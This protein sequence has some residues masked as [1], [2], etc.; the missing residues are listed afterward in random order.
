MF[1]QSQGMFDRSSGTPGQPQTMYEQ[2]P[3]QGGRLPPVVV[4]G[5]ITIVHRMPSQISRTDNAAP[6]TAR[7]PYYCHG[8]SDSKT[9]HLSH[10]ILAHLTVACR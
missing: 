5:G 4:S 7:T 6:G 3:G 8:S 1:D 9:D 10:L 2:A